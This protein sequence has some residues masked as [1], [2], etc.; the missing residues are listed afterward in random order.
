MSW[1]RGLVKILRVRVGFRIIRRFV[2]KIGRVGVFFRVRVIVERIDVIGVVIF[3]V[4][5]GVCKVGVVNVDRINVIVVG[6]RVWVYLGYF[7]CLSSW[8]FCLSNWGWCLRNWG[9]FLS[10]RGYWLGNW[11]FFLSNWGLIYLFFGGCFFRIRR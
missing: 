8:D 9:Y 4:F 2:G 11:G 5:C 7:F 1:E 3:F 10:N 6:R